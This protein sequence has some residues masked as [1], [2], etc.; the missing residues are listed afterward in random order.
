MAHAPARS[1]TP[2]RCI[3]SSGS[4]NNVGTGFDGS[5]RRVAGK[6]SK[7]HHWV[8]GY[9]VPSIGI[10]NAPLWVVSYGLHAGQ[11]FGSLNSSSSSFTHK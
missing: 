1:P 8:D 5:G 9:L 3:A 7:G 6:D 11:C 10:L 4:F 2:E